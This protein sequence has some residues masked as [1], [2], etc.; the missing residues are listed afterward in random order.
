MQ[1]LQKKMTDSSQLILSLILKIRLRNMKLPMIMKNHFNARFVV[2]VSEVPVM[3]NLIKLFIP[4]K[5]LLLVNTAV[6]HLHGL[7]HVKFMKEFILGKNPMLAMF[8]TTRQELYH[9]CNL[10]KEYTQARSIKRGVLLSLPL[11][12]KPYEPKQLVL[13]KIILAHEIIH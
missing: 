13:N 10:I 8:V 11:H 3:W 4:E 2:N 7:K 12:L 6:K 1:D 5:S 9:L